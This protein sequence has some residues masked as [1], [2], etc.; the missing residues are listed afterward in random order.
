MIVRSYQHDV[1]CDQCFTRA[2]LSMTAMRDT[3]AQAADRGWKRKREPYEGRKGPPSFV[4]LCPTCT[5]E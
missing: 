2:G 1:E 4:D 5:G 3:R